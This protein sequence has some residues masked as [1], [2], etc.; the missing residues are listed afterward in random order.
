MRK[1]FCVETARCEQQ[2]RFLILTQYFPP[3]IGAAQTRLE[4]MAAELRRMGHEVEIVTAMPNYPRGRIFPEYRRRVYCR[5]IRDGVT[6]H[7]VWVYAAMGG[8]LGRLL[9]YGSFVF[10]SVFGLLRAKRPDYVF[11]ESPPLPLTLT[12]YLFARVW[13]VPS[14][15]NVA[16]LWPDAALEMG[17]LEDGLVVRAIRMLEAWS[18]RHATY[19]N[20]MTEGI[21]E[22]LLSKKRLRPEKVLFLPNG[23]DTLHYHPRPVDIVLKH[24]LGLEGKK[25]ILYQGTHGH[26][27]GLDSL[28]RAAK[29]LEGKPDVH[30]LLIGDGSERPRLEQ[31][32]KSL[33]LSNVTFH[34]PVPIKELPAYFSLAVCG[35][36]S[37]RDLPHLN[38]ARPAKMFPI[39]A[40]GKPIIFVG[41]GEGAQLAERAQAAVVVPPENPQA[42]AEAVLQLIENPETVQEL[43]ANGR[44]FVET[45][46][47]WSKLVSAWMAQLS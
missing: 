6:V 33:N 2:M 44:R 41:R 42:L 43:G 40:S 45:N 32:Q 19:V 13:G 9:N 10:M 18:Y 27:H 28:L 11:V 16:D 7:R 35:L 8:G 24:Q 21:R 23:V 29:L 47:Q 31:L 46:L 17:F 26:A 14:I 22:S 36:V 12:G 3:E 5:E 39:L 4:A 1:G 37:L 34:D 15:M 30:F 38:G 20:A 25:V